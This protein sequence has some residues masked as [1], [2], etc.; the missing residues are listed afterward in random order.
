MQLVWPEGAD[1]AAVSA[2]AEGIFLARDLVTTPA[3]DLG[4]QH[5]AAEALAVAAA[6]GASGSVIVGGELLEAGYPAIHTVGR[7]SANE[8]RLVDFRCEAQHACAPGP[9]G[10]ALM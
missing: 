9:A 7:A 8:P 5:L 2:L 3:E 4:P 10:A 6:H 1:Q